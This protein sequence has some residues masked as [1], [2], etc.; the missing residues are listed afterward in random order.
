MSKDFARMGGQVY[1]GNGVKSAES[2]PRRLRKRKVY[3]SQATP[4]LQQNLRFVAFLRSRTRE[5]S[6]INVTLARLTRP[7]ARGLPTYGSDEYRGD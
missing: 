7:T 1:K 5:N 2:K 4:L 3:D 6:G